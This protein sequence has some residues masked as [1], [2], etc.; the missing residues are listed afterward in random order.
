MLNHAHEMSPKL[1]ISSDCLWSRKTNNNIAILKKKPL[2]PDCSLIPIFVGVYLDLTEKYVVSPNDL[3]FFHC[4]RVILHL[5]L[6]SITAS[7]SPT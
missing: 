5:T 7:S 4:D 3:H 1:L 2:F 6:I